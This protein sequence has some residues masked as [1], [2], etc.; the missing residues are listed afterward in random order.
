MT[1]LSILA[2]LLKLSKGTTSRVLFDGGSLRK[3]V[4]NSCLLRCKLSCALFSS[5][6]LGSPLY[7]LSERAYEYV[8]FRVALLAS[9]KLSDLSRLCSP[10]SFAAR[11][12]GIVQQGFRRDQPDCICTRHHSRHS[13]RSRSVAR[14]AVL[15]RASDPEGGQARIKKDRDCS[16]LGRN[17]WAFFSGQSFV[18]YF[19]SDFTGWRE[20]QAAESEEESKEEVI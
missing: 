15:Q 13:H 17:A 20:C 10:G 2:I 12:R 9:H 16:K 19:K 6:I 3:I 11:Q 7:I 14:C 1:G 4:C 8:D 18:D 5:P